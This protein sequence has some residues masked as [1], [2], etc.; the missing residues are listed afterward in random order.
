M[1][2]TNKNSKQTLKVL[3][4]AATDKFKHIAISTKLTTDKYTLIFVVC[5]PGFV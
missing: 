1:S 2:N 3:M 4:A 5:I